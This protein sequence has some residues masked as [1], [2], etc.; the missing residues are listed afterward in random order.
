MGPVTDPRVPVR[1]FGSVDAEVDGQRVV[2]SPRD[3]SYLGLEG[4]GAMVW[5]LI[6]G[7]RS[8]EQIVSELERRCE[9]P[10][11]AI[12]ADTLAFLEKLINVGLIADW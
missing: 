4:S 11:G 9:A 10:E 3:F 6:D 8:I 12:R 7:T 2:L 1:E 5:D